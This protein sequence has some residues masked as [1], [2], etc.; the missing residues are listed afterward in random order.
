MFVG[1]SGGGN[2]KGSDFG[3]LVFFLG[4]SG[5]LTSDF[6]RTE[7]FCGGLEEGVLGFEGTGLEA[8]LAGCLEATFATGFA[9]F[10]IEA[11]AGGVTRA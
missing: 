4:A 2:A 3:C 8:T 1:S 6:G 10:A 11:L 5:F 7:G 9:F